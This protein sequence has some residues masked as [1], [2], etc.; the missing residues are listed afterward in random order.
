MDQSFADFGPM[1]AAVVALT[2]VVTVGW[3][4]L[5]PLVDPVISKN[6]L[7]GDA[8][9]YHELALNL[10]AGRGFS[11]ESGPT[12]FQ[13]PGYPAFLAVVYLFFEP[14]LTFARLTQALLHSVTVLL[15]VASAR[16]VLRETRSA[17]LASLIFGLN[18]LLIY[19]AGWVYSETLFIF[20][21]A[22]ALYTAAKITADGSELKPALYFGLGFLEGIA[23]LIKSSFLP[24]I[25]LSFLWGYWILP[26]RARRLRLLMA[27]LVIAGALFP[28]TPWTVRN[29]LVHS[30][31]VVISTNSGS[32]LNGGNNPL[33]DG[34]FTPG[35]PYVVPGYSE[36]ASD[37]L[38]TKAA[39]DYICSEPG[40][41]LARMPQKLYKLLAV[42]EFGTSGQFPSRLSLAANAVYLVFLCL[43]IRGV[44]LSRRRQ[45]HL[46]YGYLLVIVTI[47]TSLVFFGATRFQLPLAPVFAMLAAVGLTNW[48]WPTAGLFRVKTDVI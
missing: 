15:V 46:L 3:V 32:N 14:Q 27:A 22:A 37:L 39:L 34:G 6:P 4:Y 10:L 2:L 19:T 35:Y 43:C 26:A 20:V 1:V 16:M 9:R 24:V 28:I 12:S 17:V 25:P 38:L 48:S 45:R 7:H 31:L 8:A 11:T 33:A 13:A 44:I 36:T 42:T 30:Q 40:A 47:G 18:P 41:F 29:Y 5:A 21:V 23:A